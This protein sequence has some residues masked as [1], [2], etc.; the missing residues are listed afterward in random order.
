MKL[1]LFSVDEL[2]TQ[3]RPE[4]RQSDRSASRQSGHSSIDLEASQALDYA[5]LGQSAAEEYEA[6]PHLSDNEVDQF[7]QSLKETGNGA[8]T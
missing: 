8:T 3:G 2:E 4:T 6:D 1:T 7:L 5:N